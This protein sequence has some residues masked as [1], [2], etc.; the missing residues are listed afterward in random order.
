MVTE[1]WRNGKQLLRVFSVPSY[2]VLDSVVGEWEKELIHV[3]QLP[4]D[5][6]IDYFRVWQRKDLASPVNGTLAN[7]GGPCPTEA[8]G[9]IPPK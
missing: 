1:N 3:E 5:L 6:V 7:D 8:F 9:S 4:G 2:C